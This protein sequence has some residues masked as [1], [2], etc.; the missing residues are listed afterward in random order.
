MNN[1]VNYSNLTQFLTGDKS[2][3]DL[4]NKLAD[5]AKSNKDYSK[6]IK[7]YGTLFQGA[8]DL[9][10]L[11][12]EAM[13]ISSGIDNLSS[14]SSES[15]RAIAIRDISTG[16]FGMGSTLA[17]HIPGITGDLIAAELE[18]AVT[19]LEDGCNILIDYIERLEKLEAD[20]DAIVNG[21]KETVEGME[22]I[23]EVAEAFSPLI[24]G[25]AAP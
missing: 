4:N 5:L 17:G 12:E 15:E 25:G 1:T 20:I 9:V 22:A 21:D 19:V 10:S 2:Q 7:N 24:D 6:W 18:T 11:S 8:N 14:Y 23:N 16:I 3:S 13:K